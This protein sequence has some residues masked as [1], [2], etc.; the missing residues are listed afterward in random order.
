M[1]DPSVN[2]YE[3]QFELDFSMRQSVHPTKTHL[4]DTAVK[5][6]DTQLPQEI[7]VDEILEKSGI[8]K[9][10]LYHHFEDLA[11]LL[12]SAQV[13]RYADWVDRSI[14]LIVAI[15]SKAKSKDEVFEGVKKMTYLTQSAEYKNFRYERART[16]GNSQ[17][18]ERFQKLLAI[19][20]ER[21]TTG[22]TDIFREVIE[23]GYFDK[24]LNPHVAAIFIQSYTLG[25]IVDDI[26]TNPISS[27]EWDD[28]IDQMVFKS[29]FSH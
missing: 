2:R 4:I 3:L 15:I 11:E 10:S 22:L 16:I 12:E 23:K 26:V 27:K 28:F 21:L 1:P 13:A 14:E 17:G 7:A 8:S 24:N 19:E 9:G 25:K 20:Q 29:M 18:H 6:L 5:L